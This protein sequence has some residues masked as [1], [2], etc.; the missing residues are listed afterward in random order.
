[1]D[2][3]LSSAKRDKILID[4]AREDNKSR[5]DVVESMLQS[6]QVFAQCRQYIPR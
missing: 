5:K 4:E 3:Q 6:N 2:R 1:M